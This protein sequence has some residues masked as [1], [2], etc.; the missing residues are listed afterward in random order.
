MWSTHPGVTTKLT[1]QLSSLVT[2]WLVDIVI[3]N[4]IHMVS[5][6]ALHKIYGIGRY[7]RENTNSHKTKRP[8]S[9]HPDLCQISFVWWLRENSVLCDMTLV[10]LVPVKSTRRLLM[11]WYPFGDRSSAT[12]MNWDDTHHRSAYVC[13]CPSAKYAPSQQQPLWPVANHIMQR[14]NWILQIHQLTLT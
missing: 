14:F 6:A 11:A 10:I 5:V 12:I 4:C 9:C 8:M 1:W 13:W 3:A 2:R 7:S